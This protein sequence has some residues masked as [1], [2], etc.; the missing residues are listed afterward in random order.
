MIYL[1]DKLDQAKH[2]KEHGCYDLNC[3]TCKFINGVC[4]IYFGSSEDNV[5][6]EILKDV[7]QYLRKFKL[8]KLN[9]NR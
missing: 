4:R 1:T 8:D 9:E 6:P 7:E 2:I 3:N 5:Q